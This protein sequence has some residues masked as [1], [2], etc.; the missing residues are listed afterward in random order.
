MTADLHRLSTADHDPYA[1][2]PAPPR[3]LSRRAKTKWTELMAEYD[4][5]DSYSRSVLEQALC[6]FDD[7]EECRKQVK[8]DG[9]MVPS[10][11]PGRPAKSKDGLQGE[12]FAL[13]DDKPLR[14]HPMLAQ[15]DKFRSSMVS[16]LVK[17]RIDVSGSGNPVPVAQS[18]KIRKTG[19]IPEKPA[20]MGK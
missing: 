6:A 10:T 5:S 20:W 14:P 15:V 16:Y 8:K 13:A 19:D 7:A 9:L 1:H 12:M 17:L 3:G 4:L 18:P 2:L 11:G